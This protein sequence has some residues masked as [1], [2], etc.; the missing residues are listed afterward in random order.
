MP[1]YGRRFPVRLAGSSVGTL[2]KVIFSVIL[3]FCYS[4]KLRG[5]HSLT[6]VSGHCGGHECCSSPPLHPFKLQW[7]YDLLWPM[8]C[9]LK[10]HGSFR[11]VHSKPVWD[12]PEFLLSPLPLPHDNWKWPRWQL[13]QQ[14]GLWR[15][16]DEKQSQGR[17]YCL[18]PL[19]FQAVAEW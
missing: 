7:P 19:R 18:N 12:L 4:G 6:Q 17:T 1:L 2:E 14:V 9:K 10:Q 3:I 5:L 16:D 15:K 8:K 13:P 11:Q